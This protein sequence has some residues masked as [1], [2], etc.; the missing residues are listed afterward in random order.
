[1]AFVRHAFGKLSTV[2]R[3]PH[4]WV[5]AI[6]MVIFTISYYSGQLGIAWFPFGE[7]LLAS[8]YAHDVYRS[9][10]LIPMVYMAIV[11]RFR[12]ALFISIIVLIIVLPRGLLYS[13][14]PDPVLRPVIFVVVAGLATVALG[15]ERDR[16]IRENKA[17]KDL[18][19]NQELLKESVSRYRDLFD[20]ASDAIYIRDLEGKIL[21]VNRAAIEITGYPASQLT[22]LNIS[23]LLTPESAG[24][25]MEMQQKQLD[26]EVI[27]HRYELELVKKDGSIAI[28]DAAIRI[29]TGNDK[30]I[31][32]Q[33]TLRDVTERKRLEENMSFYVSQ[34]T[35][36]QE[37]ERKRIAREL[38]DETAQD[39]AALLLE[40]G[41]IMSRKEQIPDN[42][43]ESL[44][45]LR[46]NAERT[47]EGVRRFSQALRPRMLD[48][49]GLLASL[50]WL[51][52]DLNLNSGIK[53]R[54]EVSG[55]KRRLPT[56]V[57]MVLFRIAQEALRNIEKHSKASRADVSVEFS[58]GKTKIII[59]DDGK[60]FNLSGSL[61][62]L[63]RSGKLG[64]AG[65]EERARIA[66]GKLSVQSEPGKGTVVE[67][68]A[69]F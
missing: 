66:G 52:D 64:L 67:I 31:A 36:A 39:I 44:S 24:I 14:N 59:S 45:S 65:M 26:G 60:G 54:V 17:L 63:P 62:E 69:P 6:L 42:I 19:L 34:I 53:T 68:E 16:R 20:S 22:K 18:L 51:A 49:L 27:G 61:T 3:N 8:E 38:H 47:M 7:R 25:T 58:K 9:L 33:A 11:F 10:F 37:E 57:E 55:N 4:V 43:L 21:E 35:K 56:E 1:M 13:I 41:A 29:L 28:V 12:G 46:N 32:V 40:L 23:D 15:L 48:E 5:I 30:P 2:A 50:E